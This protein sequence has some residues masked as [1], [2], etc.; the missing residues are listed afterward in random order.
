MILKK[1]KLYEFISDLLHYTNN[2]QKDFLN[3]N[4]CCLDELNDRQQQ[5]V[6]GKKH[7]IKN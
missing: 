1:E 6:G 7:I 3:E 4:M 5:I 2:L